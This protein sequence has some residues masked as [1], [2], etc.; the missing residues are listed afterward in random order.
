MM[1]DHLRIHLHLKRPPSGLS[2]PQ[3]DSCIH[4]SQN[5]SFG[6]CQPEKMG[7]PVSADFDEKGD[8]LTLRNKFQSVSSGWSGMAFKVHPNTAC[9]KGFYPYIEIKASPAKLYQAH[10]VYGTDNL[11][12]CV[13]VML[14]TLFKT[15]PHL[16]RYIDLR[17]SE[18]RHININYF[19]KVQS[20]SIAKRI[21]GFLSNVSGGQSKGGNSYPTSH[22]WG[23]KTTNKDAE[24]PFEMKSDIRHKSN[25]CYLKYEELQF[26]VGEFLK[27]GH[28]EEL[29]QKF[30]LVNAALHHTTAGTVR[31]ETRLK[32]RFLHSQGV[33]L[34]LH[35]FIDESKKRPGL[36]N[37]L[38]NKSFKDIFKALEGQKMTI[39]DDESI[40]NKLKMVFQKTTKKGNISYTLAERYYSTYQLIK[41][42]GYGYVKNHFS[43]ATLHRHEKAFHQ[44]G[45]SRAY[46]QNVGSKDYEQANV[47][48]FAQLVEIKFDEQSVPDSE[49][50]PVN[51]DISKY[52]SHLRRVA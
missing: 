45:L 24:N 31:F 16:E 23:G 40:L 5:G 13:N 28:S 30:F 44:I 21:I 4:S 52:R 8:L 10:N 35:L 2:F 25:K 38:F 7:V 9:L 26:R 36:M 39:L 51:F 43:R 15:Y 6:W 32:D 41:S 47:I 22:Y 14:E 18:I 12:Y 17:A 20:H 3:N 33:P 50:P 46:L 42:H 11:E 48:P 37:E 1:I 29:K 27:S 19:V 34:N 49:L